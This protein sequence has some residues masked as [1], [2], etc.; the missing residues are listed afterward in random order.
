VS[1]TG[2]ACRPGDRMSPSLPRTTTSLDPSDAR[3][4]GT[5]RNSSL[6]RSCP[7]YTFRLQKHQRQ[8]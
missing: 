2:I 7:H 5:A 8:I 4:H 1:R 3:G 6:G